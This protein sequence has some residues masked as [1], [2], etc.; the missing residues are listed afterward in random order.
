MSCKTKTRVLYTIV[1]SITY[2]RYWAPRANSVQSNHAN[3]FLKYLIYHMMTDLDIWLLILW[4][5]QHRGDLIETFKILNGIEGTPM[6]SLFSLN[7]SVTRGNS[8]KLNKSCSRL[9]TRHNFF[10]Q[11]VVNALNQFPEKVIACDIVNRFKNAIDRHFF[12]KY[13]GFLWFG[14]LTPRAA[15]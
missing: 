3:W 9:N 4:S 14:C 15:L 2:Q 6:T 5:W 7:T 8:L 13:I 11:C 10:S 12:G 1:E